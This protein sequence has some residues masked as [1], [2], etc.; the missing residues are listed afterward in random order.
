MVLSTLPHLNFPV[1]FEKIFS[2]SHAMQNGAG[3]KALRR[4]HEQHVYIAANISHG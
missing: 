4:F 2:T 3:Q 1:R